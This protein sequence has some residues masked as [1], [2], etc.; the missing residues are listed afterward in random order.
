M[1][2]TIKLT[3]PAGQYHATPWGRHVNE[4]VPE[5][6]PSPWRFLRALVAVWKR[7][8]PDLPEQQVKRVLEQLVHPPRFKLPRH[9]VAHTRH[10]MPWEKKGPTDRTLVFDTF[11][12]VGRGN[13]DPLLIGWPNGDLSPEDRS[14]LKKLLENLS[15]L[16]RAES[17]VHAELSDDSVIFPIGEADPDEPNP[18]PVLC[19]DP[20]SAFGDEYY[21]PVPDAKKIK[22]GLKPDEYLFDCPRWHLCLDTQTIHAERWAG[23]PGAK[24]LNYARPSEQ[25]IVTRRSLPRREERFAI[26][27]FLLDGPVLPLTT[28]TVRVAEKFR[29][30]A[31]SR[32]GNW[33]ERY[34][35]RAQSF[36]RTDVPGKYSSTVLSGKALDGTIR[37][38]HRHAYYLPTSENDPHRITHVTVFAKDGFGDAEVAAL[39]SLRKL[40]W[41]DES[42]ELRV[43]LVG[44]GNRGDFNLDLFKASRVW[45]SITPFV[46]H[47]HY[48]RRGRKRDLLDRNA[49]PRLAFIQLAAREEIER[50]CGQAP[51]IIEPFNGIAGVPRA[52]DFRRYRERGGDDGRGRA[53]GFLRLEFTEPIPGP[54]SIGY[55][56]HFGLGLFIPGQ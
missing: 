54:I 28:D 49:D 9:R 41:R 39:C 8:C 27:R 55:G 17:W 45:H 38:E 7:T 2:I 51:A 42:K 10:Y 46:V 37:T 15:S 11:V 1:P 33:C 6:P 25:S 23:V 29:H 13:Q 26:A 44:L 43:Q 40:K 12:S 19:P 36:L 52:I 21:P 34:P 22:K 47:R 14:A 35:E 20:S 4:G 3:F 32:F 53:F 24:W 31:M 5:W 50:I 56:S 18:I 48:K 16:G 30:A